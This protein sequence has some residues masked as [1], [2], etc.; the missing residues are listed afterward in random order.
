MVK[1]KSAFA[2]SCLVR[3]MLN[4]HGIK[5][6]SS[7]LSVVVLF[8]SYLAH[9]GSPYEVDGKTVYFCTITMDEFSDVTGVSKT[10]IWTTFKLLVD[11]GLMYIREVDYPYIGRG[12]DLTPFLEDVTHGE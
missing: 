1:L 10:S 6:T 4:E 11:E 3:K 2:L 8:L 5:L 7:G 12:M 9:S